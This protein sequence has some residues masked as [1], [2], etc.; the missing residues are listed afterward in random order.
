MFLFRKESVM[1]LGA[2]AF[3]TVFDP[4]KRMATECARAVLPP[5]IADMADMP[6][7]TRL[8]PMSTE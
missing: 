6:L 3:G 4:S 5:Q 1:P 8:G 7:K 2:E